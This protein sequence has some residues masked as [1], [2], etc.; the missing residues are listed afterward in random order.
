M[1]I[2]NSKKTW[3]MFSNWIEKIENRLFIAHI[4]IFI[5]LGLAILWLVLAFIAPD[6][7]FNK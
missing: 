6:I 3:N 1:I 5:G 4:F 2:W 7:L